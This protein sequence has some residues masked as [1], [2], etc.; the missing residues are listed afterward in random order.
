MIDVEP[1]KAKILAILKEAGL[2]SDKL[3][4]AIDSA[5]REIASDLEEVKPA[6]DE[7]E[8]EDG[9]EKTSFTDVAWNTPKSDLEADAYCS[10]CLIDEN[11]P[12]QDKV[13][14]KCHL[15]VRSR[16]GGPVNKNALRN[17]SAR[18]SS[19]QASSESKAKARR[20]LIS[21]MNAAGID[22]SLEKVAGEDDI[23][24]ALRADLIYPQAELKRIAYGVVYPVFPPGEADTQSHRMSPEEIEKMAHGFM[25]NSRAYD[26]Q[27]REFGI[28]PA[29]AVVV[30]SYIAPVDFD[31]AGTHISKGSWIVATKF[32][33]TMWDR[34]ISRELRAYS[35][36]GKGK[37]KKPKLQG[38]GS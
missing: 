2:S 36:R 5:L 32:S 17:A 28:P 30:E 31:M 12:G 23:D 15:P 3:E 13:K 38:N 29:D 7:D 19:T 33:P 34:I 27:H 10:V 4:S 18:L 37:L 8:D 14:D 25:Q 24:I 9:V 1:I 21:L 22:T 6:A 16:P 35:I 11:P 20:R 26:I